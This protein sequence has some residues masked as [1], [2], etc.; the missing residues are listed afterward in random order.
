M[1]RLLQAYH[2]IFARRLRG[3][4]RPRWCPTTWRGTSASIGSAEWLAL[5]RD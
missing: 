3:P 1:D 5:A 2:F 4:C